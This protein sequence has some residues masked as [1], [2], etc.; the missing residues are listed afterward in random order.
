M[1]TWIATVLMPANMP[2]N[3]FVLA[4]LITLLAVIIHMLLGSV[5][6]VMGVAI[7]AVLAATAGMGIN[8]LAPTL[9][10]YMAI[11]AHYILPFQH[12]NMLVGSGDEN[13]MYSQKETIRLGIPLIAVMF[14]VNVLIMVPWFKIVGMI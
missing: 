5:I 11:A 6:A 13:G 1:N 9:L 3:M 14:I 2:A 8:P 10:I 7:P 12:L 4:A